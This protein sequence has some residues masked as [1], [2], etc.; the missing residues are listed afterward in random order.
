[1]PLEQ[2]P[3]TNFHELNLDWI[4]SIVK[5]MKDSL[6]LIDSLE[7]Q[8]I[9][10]KDYVDHYFESDEVHQEM[11][12]EIDRYLDELFISGYFAELISEYVSGGTTTRVNAFPF[13]S[14]NN[15]GTYGIQSF[16]ITPTKYVLFA[17]GGL[18]DEYHKVIFLNHNGQFLSEL[19]LAIN[20]HS[21]SAFYEDGYIYLCGNGS[22]Y[23][24]LD[25]D[26]NI[27]DTLASPYPIVNIAG[28][29]GNRIYCEWI[30]SSHVNLHYNEQ[31]NKIVEFNGTLQ[32]MTMHD[33]KVYLCTSTTF[34]GIVY[35]YN[36]AFTLLNTFTMYPFVHEIE[37]IQFY[38]NKCIVL[39]AYG[40]A[41]KT[42][43]QY[44][45]IGAVIDPQL[46]ENYSPTRTL[47]VD[48][49]ADG[50]YDGSATKPINELSALTSIIYNQNLYSRTRDITIDIGS[51]ITLDT[52]LALW[53]C[54][55]N[56]TISGNSHTITTNGYD[57]NI[58]NVNRLRMQYLTFTGTDNINLESIPDLHLQN[59]TSD[60]TMNIRNCRGVALTCSN[61]S[62]SLFANTNSTITMYNCT[63]TISG[64]Y[65]G[66][67]VNPNADKV[68]TLTTGATITTPVYVLYKQVTV[69][70]GTN[71]DVSYP[72]IP[73]TSAFYTLSVMT[74][75]PTINVV[76][77][78]VGGNILRVYT[79]NAT[80][81]SVRVAI[82][83][84]PN[85]KG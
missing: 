33:N 58:I 30:D 44:A 11:V 57:V 20:G 69:K 6:V 66:Q 60:M 61:T 46:V 76:A 36:L 52:N 83:F 25:E 64:S 5:E 48:T 29:N 39:D 19:P 38:D 54:P 41:L 49:T 71:A 73:D 2:F 65:G 22:T 56:L 35:Q 82:F 43:L 78:F 8:F 23:Y 42:F 1:M 4:I 24:K 59:I 68:T 53:N 40:S 75:T 7:E 15:D 55:A 14:Y 62:T 84:I 16:V 10:L 31:Y 74:S 45:N 27:I 79:D 70:S 18:N 34:G 85:Y 26:G 80:D 50:F 32:G 13:W 3:Y 28:E 63:G 21:N 12:D 77:N 67:Y 51:N 72:S 81:V 9:A 37:N 47:Y 17:V